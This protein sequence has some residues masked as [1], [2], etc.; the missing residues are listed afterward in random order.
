MAFGLQAMGESLAQFS[1]CYVKCY[2]ESFVRGFSAVMACALAAS[3]TIFSCRYG[4]DSTQLIY[5]WDYVVCSH[6]L[7]TFGFNYIF[8]YMR[9]IHDENL[10][11]EK[12]IDSLTEFEFRA[13]PDGANT[14][15]LSCCICFEDYKDKQM[16]AHMPCNP[17]HIFHKECITQWL[18]QQQCCPLCRSDK[19]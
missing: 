11:T 2:R 15:N 9:S 7:V 5:F 19:V 18:K 16:L 12:A 8:C 1:S 17:N 4:M 13:Q 3:T 10:R 14:H 6:V